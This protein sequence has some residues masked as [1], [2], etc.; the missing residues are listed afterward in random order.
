MFDYKHLPPAGAKLGKAKAMETVV[1]RDGTRLYK[2]YKVRFW[3]EKMGAKEDYFII[4]K[5]RS[6]HLTPYEFKRRF[7]TII[8]GGIV[9]L[10]PEGGVEI[11]NP[12]TVEET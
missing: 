8:K 12:V 5:E 4:Y 10:K 6:Y 11:E 9:K 7:K 2:K 3:I 1:L